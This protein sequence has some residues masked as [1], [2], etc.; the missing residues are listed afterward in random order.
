[1]P[2]PSMRSMCTGI[3]L[4]CFASRTARRRWVIELGNTNVVAA[5]SLL[6]LLGRSCVRLI[7]CALARK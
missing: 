3:R 7:V 4:R 1:M 5:D 6:D 2:V